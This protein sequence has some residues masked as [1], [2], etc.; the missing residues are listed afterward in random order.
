M[1]ENR[2]ESIFSFFQYG[3]KR[4][5]HIS[6]DAGYTVDQLA[7]VLGD[8][9]PKYL[10]VSN[11]TKQVAEEANSKLNNNVKIINVDEIDLT[12]DYKIKRKEFAN[13]SNKDVA[14]LVYTSGTTGNPKGVMITYEN[15]ETNMAV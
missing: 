13:D 10:F 2:P 9:E 14:V 1:M 11:K 7:Y 3:L 6:L 4:N 8:S 5:S 12:T 15:I